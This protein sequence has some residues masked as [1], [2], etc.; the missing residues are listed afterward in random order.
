MDDDEAER[1]VAA[2]QARYE[3]D[4]ASIPRVPGRGHGKRPTEDPEPES[5]GPDAPPEASAKDGA[6]DGPTA[7]PTRSTRK[8]KA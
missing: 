6:A 7:R 1:R 5:K 3:G 8:P 2:G 4:D